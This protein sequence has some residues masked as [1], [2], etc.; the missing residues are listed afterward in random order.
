M[1]EFQFLSWAKFATPMF[2][3]AKIHNSNVWKRKS[4]EFQFWN[5]QNSE[6]QCLKKPKFTIPIF[7]K[8]KVHSSNV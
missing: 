4:P 3:N 2:G 8:A 7:G 5:C 1:K 6:F